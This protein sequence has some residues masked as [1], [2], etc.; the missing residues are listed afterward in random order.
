MVAS[1][2]TQV[3]GLAPATSTPPLVTI[4]KPSE[5][6]VD[7]ANTQ[8]M[9]DMVMLQAANLWA[10][11]SQGLHPLHRHEIQSMPLHFVSDHCANR[12]RRVICYGDSLTAGFC[13]SGAQFEPYGRSLVKELAA[14]GVP[15]EIVVSGHTGKTAEEM[16][17]S[18]DTSIVDIA[19]LEGK[20]LARILDDDVTP[21][22]VIIMTGTN[23]MGKGATPEAIVQDIADLHA[24]CHRRGVATIALVPPPAPCAQPHRENDRIHLRSIISEWAAGEAGVQAVVDPAQWAPLYGGPCVWDFDGLHFSPS[25]SALLAQGLAPLVAK[26]LPEEVDVQDRSIS[27]EF[28]KIHSSSEAV[29]AR[30]TPIHKPDYGFWSTATCSASG[31]PPASSPTAR[32]AVV[33]A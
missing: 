5:A 27:H 21:D 14:R 17:A 28:D 22:L 2:A 8:A 32:V 26:L 19:G 24:A 12:P 11:I 20:G 4:G 30:P 15:C 25:G 10:Q 18:L 3:P 23:D 1:D 31:E 29:S 7:C 6:Q 9:Y 16:V 13:S 33:C